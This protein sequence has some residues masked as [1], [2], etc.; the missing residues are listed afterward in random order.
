MP[1]K[2]NRDTDA[3]N[4]SEA[5]KPYKVNEFLGSN[6]RNKSQ[7]E[8][9]HELNAALTTLKELDTQM[10]QIKEKYEVRNKTDELVK[11]LCTRCVN[12]IDEVFSV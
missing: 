11:D 6:I 12:Q 4:L 2:E 9:M 8:E 10:N 5:A 7:V 3:A 1:D